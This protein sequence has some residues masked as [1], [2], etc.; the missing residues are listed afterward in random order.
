VVCEQAEWNALDHDQPGGPT[1]VQAGIASEA[2][3]ER[4]ARDGMS[5]GPKWL[6][7]NGGAR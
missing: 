4:V 1:L 7:V 2:E 6:R 5:P 3:A